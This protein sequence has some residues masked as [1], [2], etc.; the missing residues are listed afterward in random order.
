MIVWDVNSSLTL[1]A[2]AGVQNEATASN[3]AMSLRMAPRLRQ[4]TLGR[5]DRVGR[6]EL[7]A[8]ATGQCERS[9]RQLGPTPCPY[10]RIAQRSRRA[11]LGR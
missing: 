3:G 1:L 6:V 8:H 4:A 2:R 11:T 9:I 5:R 7:V 10:L